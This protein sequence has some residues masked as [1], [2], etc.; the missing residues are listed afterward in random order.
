MTGS[1]AGEVW[2]EGQ[3]LRA[4]TKEPGLLQGQGDFLEEGTF[5]LSS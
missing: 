4:V 5:C 3:G 1:G 2:E